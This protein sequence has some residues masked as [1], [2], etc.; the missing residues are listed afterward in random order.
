M[1]LNLPEYEQLIQELT[2]RNQLAVEKA[3]AQAVGEAQRRGLVGQTGTSDIEASLR[4]ARTQPIVESGQGQIASLLQQGAD[5]AQEERMTKEG[6]ANTSAENE[7]QRQWQTGER[8]GN[9]TWQGQ[10]AG[11]VNPNTGEWINTGY[12]TGW[13]SAGVNAAENERERAYDEM[14]ANRQRQWSL[15]DAKKKKRGRWGDIAAGLVG[16]AGQG[17]F[18][19]VGTGVG[20]SWFK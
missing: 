11:Y 6:W 3:N 16:G 15:E 20:Y 7:K 13:G 2:R 8:T 14:M 5:R 1:A 19:G 10:M 9:Q 12:G 4:A 17:L 18:Q